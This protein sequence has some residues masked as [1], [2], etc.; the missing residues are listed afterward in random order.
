[1][2]GD[3]ADRHATIWA[4]TPGVGGFLVVP[5]SLDRGPAARCEAKITPAM[6]PVGTVGVP[7]SVLRHAVVSDQQLIASGHGKTPGY[8]PP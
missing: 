6:L 1:M 4:L 7:A 3:D 5:A 8:A 2:R